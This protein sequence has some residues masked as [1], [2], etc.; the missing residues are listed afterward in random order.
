MFRLFPFA[1]F[2][3]AISCVAGPSTLTHL[4]N[5]NRAPNEEPS[6]FLTANVDQFITLGN[7][8]VVAARGNILYIA[9]ASRDLIY[10]YN[11]DSESIYPLYNVA[12]HLSG[13]PGGIFIN[14]DLSF[15]VADPLARRVLLFD[16]NGNL[17][18]Q[19]QDQKN[20]SNPL[21]ICR[22]ELFNRVFVADSYYDHVI[23]FNF[24]GLPLAA[25]GGRG[26]R[27]DQFMNIIDMSCGID[28]V[29]NIFLIDQLTDK[30][31]VYGFDG[32][33][34]RAIPRTE[35][36]HPSS[37]AVD[38]GERIYIS[39]DF[40]DT[41]KIYDRHGLIEVFG[42]TGSANGR[43]RM[44]R[45]MWSDERFLYVADSVNNRI[46]VFVITP[47]IKKQDSNDAIR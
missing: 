37:I 41:I 14:N 30:I 31:K 40:D 15:Y 7:P 35:V 28:G 38:Y 25:L 23:E 44:I 11:R 21:A 43:F 17:I 10:R 9:D 42:G 36:R 24:D 13:P 47:I 16:L 18:R 33:F 3:F 2:F 20:L 5:I 39:D 29:N 32:K 26:N 8:A 22:S 19:Y 12:D 46:Q 27:S 6:S 34:V 4:S 1:L 45:D